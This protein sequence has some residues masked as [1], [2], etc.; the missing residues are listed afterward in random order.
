M[1][2]PLS[3]LQHWDYLSLV[4]PSPFASLLS[5][6]LRNLAGLIGNNGNS[7]KV[8]KKEDKQIKDAAKSITK[9]RCVLVPGHHNT[10]N[11]AGGQISFQQPIITQS[12]P[13]EGI[14]GYFN[15][16]LHDLN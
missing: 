11:R 4:S 3:A 10:A 5:L 15:Q 8:K 7:G 13:N 2:H 9:P 16:M 6:T 1:N 14:D 12:I